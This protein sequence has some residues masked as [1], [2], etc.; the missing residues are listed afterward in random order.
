[1][2]AFNSNQKCISLY[3]ESI[4]NFRFEL[5]NR[6]HQ[7]NYNTSKTSIVKKNEKKKRYHFIW[8]ESS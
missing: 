5:F 3:L 2:S 6:I 7:Q 8:K 4:E 1:M